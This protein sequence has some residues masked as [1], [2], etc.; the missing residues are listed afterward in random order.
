MRIGFN[1]NQIQSLDVRRT[2]NVRE[3]NRVRNIIDYVQRS[4]IAIAGGASRGE[5]SSG[6]SSEGDL[7][8]TID[9]QA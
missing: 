6:P 3:I 2:P 1:S 4:T 9:F 7:G 8:S 5:Y